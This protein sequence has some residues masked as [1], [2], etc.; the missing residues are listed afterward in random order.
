MR[1][2]DGEVLTG[3]IASHYPERIYPDRF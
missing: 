2:L 1:T 3:I